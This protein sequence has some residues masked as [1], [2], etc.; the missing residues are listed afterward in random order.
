MINY[1]FLKGTSKKIVAGGLAAFI[2]I[3]A[4][5]AEVFAGRTFK[6][7]VPTHNSSSAKKPCLNRKMRLSNKTRRMIYK[8]NRGLVLKTLRCER[9]WHKA[10]A[11]G[12]ADTNVSYSKVCVCYNVL[13][14]CLEDDNSDLKFAVACAGYLQGVAISLGYGCLEDSVELFR[15]LIADGS[16]EAVKSNIKC[17]T[18]DIVESI[19]DDLRCD[20]EEVSEEVSEQEMDA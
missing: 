5:S 9:I 7:A 19:C 10:I 13:S 1:D 2:A 18:D 8:M 3:S 6:T 14:Q 17:F 11:K 15:D 16:T 20:D 4:N 12:M